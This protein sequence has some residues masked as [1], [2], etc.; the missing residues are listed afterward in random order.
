MT[1]YDCIVIGCGHAGSCAALAAVESGCRKVLI[2]E[3]SPKEWAG[4]NGYFTAG[5][6]RTVHNGLHDLL[7]IVNNVTV[8]QATLIDMEPY[9]TENYIADIMR[10]GNSQSDPILVKSMVDHS[11]DAVEWLAR[12]VGIPFILAFHRQAYEVG[13]RQKFWGGLALSV[14]DGGKGLIAAHLR[15]LEK[16]GVEVWFDSPAVELVMEDFAVR[17]VIVKKNGQ[18]VQLSAT[19][20]ILA[21]GGYESSR[22][23]REKYLGPG[24]DRARV[25]GTPY[26]TGD[27]IAMAQAI[28]AK[29][30]GDWEGCH[31]TCWDANAPADTGDRVMS[32]QFTKSG[33]PLGIMVNVKGDRF[34]DEGQ[35]F[36]NYTYAK[37]GRAI[38]QQPEGC[39]FQ[40]FSGKIVELLRKEEYADEIVEKIGASSLEELADKLVEKGLEEKENLLR[41]IREY[42]AAVRSH[43]AEYPGLLWDPSVRDGLSTQSSHSSLTLPKSNWALPLEDTPFVAVKV[44]CGITFTFGGLAI[45]PNTA[46]VLSEESGK[47]IKGLFCTGE[48]VG[49]LF[50]SNYPGGSG[51]TAGAVFG[52]KAGCEAAS[53]VRDRS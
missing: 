47:P 42:N 35:D 10:L 26:N 17:G 4:G 8:E 6:H 23:L 41:T 3:K 53:L 14:E 39:A 32:N 37:F 43:R 11:R 15:A 52:R 33:Y 38:L 49:G 46:G 2:V 30:T 16:A 40:I 12:H 18:K 24:W 5:A 20:V 48:M 45:D 34:V 21:A 36:R 51:L 19:A 50:Y 1:A 13:G 7:P 28:G 44:A 9:T 27:G 31:S 22:Q 29:L 25:R